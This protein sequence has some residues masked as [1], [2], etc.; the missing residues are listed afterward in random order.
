MALMELRPCTAEDF[1]CIVANL[2]QFW[3]SERTRALHHPMFVH[4]FRETAWVVTRRGAVSGY[5]FAFWSQ[6]EPI[7][8]IH[9][10]AVRR[11][12]RRLG[13]GRSLY[14]QFEVAARQHG[15]IALKAVTSPT[16]VDSVAF[17]RRLGFDLIGV[18]RDGV[19]V[20]DDYAG[21]GMSRVVFWKD[22]AHGAM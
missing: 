17:H 8:Y 20:V 13:I 2:D 18:R 11:D 19:L 10:V 1:S 9:L 21:P 7:G 22:L 16:N 12:S 14:A 5:L 15:C 3:G 6:S 4:E